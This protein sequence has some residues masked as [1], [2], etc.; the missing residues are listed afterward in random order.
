[1][2]PLLAGAVESFAIEDGVLSVRGWC[3]EPSAPL[4]ALELRWGAET[5]AFATLSERRDVAAAHPDVAHATRSGFALEGALHKWRDEPARFQLLGIRDWLPV[6]RLRIDYEPG[7]LSLPAPPPE[8]AARTGGYGDRTRLLLRT[9][10]A[11]NALLDAVGHYRI[12]ESFRDVVH[13]EAGCA[14]L[15][16]MAARRL[17]PEATLTSIGADGDAIAWAQETGAPGRLI[18]TGPLP[19]TPLED[20]DADLVLRDRPLAELDAGALTAWLG[21]LRRV[22]RPGGY[23]ALVG[24]WAADQRAD[25]LELCGE[26]LNVV[27]AASASAWPGGDVIVLRRP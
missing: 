8:L 15:L 20:G 2:L 1:M 19:P 24:G 11:G 27:G 14:L 5:V 18:A 13:W 10:L 26:R 23:A 6:G 7:V 22:L 3:M 12:P 17:G 4:D 21:E 25:M 9:A 16:R